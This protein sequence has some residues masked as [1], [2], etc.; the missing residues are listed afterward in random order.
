MTLEEIEKEHI[1][2][3]IAES[4]SFEEAAKKLDIDSATLW[5]KRKKYNL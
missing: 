1:A 5:R 4:K 2:R 3:V